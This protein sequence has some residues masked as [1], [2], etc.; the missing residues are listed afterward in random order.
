MMFLAQQQESQEDVTKDLK[1]SIKYL[2]VRSPMASVEKIQQEQ[3][4]EEQ[5][6]NRDGDDYQLEDGVRETFRTQ[7]VWLDEDDERRDLWT[8]K[9][10]NP[11][12]DDDDKE[13]KGYLE[14]A[15]RYES[16]SKRSRFQTLSWA[17]RLDSC[18]ESQSQTYD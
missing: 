5:V 4:Y 13:D 15:Y 8:L 11:V 17:D 1:A 14:E 9:R 7:R 3:T 6:E 12:F 10:A 16:P 2:S 18:D